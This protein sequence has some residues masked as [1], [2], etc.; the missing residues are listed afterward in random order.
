MQE[1]ERQNAPLDIEDVAAAPKP[2][3]RA[4]ARPG[5]APRPAA[6]KKRAAPKRSPEPPEDDL[7][8]WLGRLVDWVAD[9]PKRLKRLPGRFIGLF[10]SWFYRIYFAVVAV[11]LIAIFVGLNWLTGVV[12]DYEIA[13]PSH[14]AQ[15][16][17]QRFENGD[18]DAIYYIDTS[19][20]DISG[21]DKAFYVESLRSVSSGKRVSWS[22][23]SESEGQRRYAVTL[24]G[25][26]FAD[27]TLVPSGE[28]TSHGNTLWKLGSVTTHVI[29]ES[30]AR[31]DDP[32][33]AAFHIQ[34]PADCTVKIDGVALAESDV[35][36]RDIS[37]L[38]DKFELPKGVRA[39]TLVEYGFNS[40][41]DAPAISVTDPSG[42]EMPVAESSENIWVCSPREDAD[43]KA[44][45]EDAVAKLAQR[46]AKFTSQ[47]LSQGTILESTVPDSPAE[48][49]LKRFSNRWA[50]T[51]K[52][53]SFEN[54]EVSQ[55]YVLSNDC[56]TCHVSFD[57]I[58]TSVRDNDYPYHTEYTFC[59]AKHRGSGKLYNLTFN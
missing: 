50:P 26:R 52:S 46:I 30:A 16:V 55:F 12:A 53:V 1:N 40:D 47:D 10:D 21:G 59:I 44:K 6:A 13:E 29:T 45:C 37:V 25:N 15:E 48:T 41:S 33:M 19:A 22:F 51:H 35:I 3:P 20:Q 7:P 23:A 5:S 43:M 9:T 14:V 57:F 32:A 54:M 49:Q 38:P 18:Y 8:E 28:T 17:A 58:I 56:F 31:A 39:P 42:A 11:A 4:Q 2:R 34:A 27:F 24:D 36:R